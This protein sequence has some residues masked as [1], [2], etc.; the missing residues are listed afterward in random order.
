VNDNVVKDSD[1]FVTITSFNICELVMFMPKLVQF[2][3]HYLLSLI[4]YL[5]KEM[6]KEMVLE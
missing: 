5:V 2:L 1:S 4:E 6:A 3:N